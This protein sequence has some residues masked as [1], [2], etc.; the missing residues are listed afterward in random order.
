MSRLVKG[1]KLP[2][3]L[4]DDANTV[5]EAFRRGARVSNNG[6]CLGYRKKMDDGKMPYVWIKYNDVIERSVSIARGIIEKGLAPGPE[7]MIGIYSTNRPEVIINVFAIF[8]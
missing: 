4:F 1:D 3:R 8:E 5:Y 7:T 2:E 6:D